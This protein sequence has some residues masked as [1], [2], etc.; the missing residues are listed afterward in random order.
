MIY[1]KEK[2]LSETQNYTQWIYANK[3]KK[4]RKAHKMF[5]GKLYYRLLEVQ[6]YIILILFPFG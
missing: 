4:R 1:L 5:T 3:N 6:I 2:S